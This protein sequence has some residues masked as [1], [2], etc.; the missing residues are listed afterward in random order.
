M[1]KLLCTL[2]MACFFIVMP[3][4]PASANPLFV[5]IR[6]VAAFIA[7][8]TVIATQIRNCQRE[9]SKFKHDYPN[10]NNNNNNNNDPNGIH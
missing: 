4:K 8:I 2:L 1:K 6:E 9:D 10:H 5:L 7:I 3:A